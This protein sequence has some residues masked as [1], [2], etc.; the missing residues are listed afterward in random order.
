VLDQAKTFIYSPDFFYY[1]GLVLGFMWFFGSSIAILLR[2]VSRI[3]HAIGF[4]I[5]DFSSAFFMIGAGIRVYQNVDKFFEWSLLKQG[6]V[7]GGT[8]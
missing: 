5:V 3:L 7:L 8:H 6:H 4:A 2:G 1:H